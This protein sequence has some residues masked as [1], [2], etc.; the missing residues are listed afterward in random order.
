MVKRTPRVVI[1]VKD[2]Q[3]QDI[4]TYIEPKVE[5]LI[6]NEDVPEDDEKHMIFW[7]T[8]I[9]PVEDVMKYFPEY[10]RFD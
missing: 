2:G 9:T 4:L 10:H 7:I 1:K 5:F 8:D 3:I 6:L